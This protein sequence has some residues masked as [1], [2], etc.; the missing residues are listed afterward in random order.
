MRE[1][2]QTIPLLIIALGT[3]G[4]NAGTAPLFIVLARSQS[5]EQMT[6]PGPLGSPAHGLRAAYGRNQRA[7]NDE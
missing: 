6:P 3:R 1:N 4:V 2:V 5:R 7:E